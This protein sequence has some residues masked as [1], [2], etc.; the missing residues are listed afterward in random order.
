[1]R[2]GMGAD[3]EVGGMTV[4]VALVPDRDSPEAAAV[5]G[6][7]VDAQVAVDARVAGVDPAV[8][9]SGVQKGAPG[10]TAAPAEVV[11]VQADSVSSVIPTAEVRAAKEGAVGRLVNSSRV[12]M[13]AFPFCR[14]VSVWPSWSRIFRPAGGPS[15]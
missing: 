11:P 15:R 10:Q 4:A 13:Y 2:A 6:G 14:T 12:W 1:M 5:R 3:V 8:V 9:L 7:G